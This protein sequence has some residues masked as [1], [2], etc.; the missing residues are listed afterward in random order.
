MAPFV[1]AVRSVW[2]DV[3]GSV[4]GYG[5]EVKGL[6]LVA[7]ATTAGNAGAIVDMINKEYAGLNGERPAKLMADEILVNPKHEVIRDILDMS[8]M[9][10]RKIERKP[11]EDA[12][13]VKPAARKTT[14]KAA[15][16]TAPRKPAA[17]AK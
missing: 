10:Q 11:V 14:T 16:K 12:P 6:G 5:V 13:V 17:A 3:K 1:V 8:G 2:S 15:T 4:M 7:T 9:V